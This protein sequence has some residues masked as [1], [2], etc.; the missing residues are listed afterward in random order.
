MGGTQCVVH[1]LQ[2]GPRVLSP[3]TGMHCAA[4]DLEH[5][6]LDP[7][8]TL[9]HLRA[10][11][12]GTLLFPP[13]GET[14]VGLPGT[15]KRLEPGVKLGH[16]RVVRPL[17]AGSMGAVYLAEHEM[18]GKQVAL[19]VLHDRLALDGELG[20]RTSTRWG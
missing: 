17:G 19:K 18:L 5:P 7:C 9:L 15:G 20:A 14:P 16:Y 2:S 10:G 6:T 11:L 12:A 13:P 3:P 4:C 8:A 1:A